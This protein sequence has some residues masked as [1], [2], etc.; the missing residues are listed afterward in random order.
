MNRQIA[1]TYAIADQTHPALDA[2]T[3]D[4]QRKKV[5]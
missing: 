3:A 4:I 1:L 5:N 2:L